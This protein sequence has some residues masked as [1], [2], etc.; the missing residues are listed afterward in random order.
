[1]ND[2]PGSSPTSAPGGGGDWVEQLMRS[3]PISS[4]A[5][6]TRASTRWKARPSAA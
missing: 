4:W 1:M 6:C 5:A 2:A 3:F